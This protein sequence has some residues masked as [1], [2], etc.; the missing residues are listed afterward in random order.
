MR[1]AARWDGQPSCW[2]SRPDRVPPPELVEKIDAVLAQVKEE[3]RME[4]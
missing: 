4:K 1:F 2:Q 3:W